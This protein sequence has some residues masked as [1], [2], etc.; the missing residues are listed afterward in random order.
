MD[1]S[2]V[3]LL[4]ERASVFFSWKRMNLLWWHMYCLWTVECYLPI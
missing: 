4:E 3:V 1:G 2:G